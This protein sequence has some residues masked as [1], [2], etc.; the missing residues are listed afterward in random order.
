MAYNYIFT[1]GPAR[2]LYFYG[3]NIIGVGKTNANTSV[4]MDLS[5]ED[6]RGGAG[7]LLFGRYYHDSLL[8]IE[9]EDSMFNLNY[10]AAALGVDVEQGGISIYESAR[11]GEAVK[12]DG[13]IT[14]AN[15]AVAFDG[16][17][18]GWYK[19]PADANWAVGNISGGVMTIP[20][21][22][23]GESYC[24]KYFYQNPDA[25][26]I[27]IKA[28]YVPKVLHIVMI[29]DL[30]SG[31]VAKLGTSSSKYGRLIMDIPRF[32]LDGTQDLAWSSTSTATVNVSGSALAYEDGE[33]C[34]EDPVYGTMTQEIFGA[35]WQDDVVAL[36]VENGNVELNQSE[37]EQL[38]VRAVFGG[39]VASK[40]YDNSN[41][42]FAV[43]Q[44]PAATANDVTVGADGIVKAGQT[45][46]EALISVNLTG[47]T[48]S[49]E[50]AYVRVTVGG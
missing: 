27:T 24:V 36:A 23:T 45:E 39:N 10:V 15:Q 2:V 19:K 26:Q 9:I 21:A 40:V 38:I 49:V 43:E 6:V 14:L 1:A 44:K 35:K 11:G 12:T 3:Q 37:Q 17:L 50:P 22:K 34:E 30:Y 7:N 46:G 29:S 42:T 32:Q 5:S 25:K 28:Q 47:Y 4:T 48:A 16:V 20:G 41:F 8:N 13:Q 18:M 31:D 33:S